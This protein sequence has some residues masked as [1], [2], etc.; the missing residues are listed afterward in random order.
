MRPQAIRSDAGSCPRAA[1]LPEPEKRLVRAVGIEPTLLSE[2]DFESSASTSSTTPATC[3]PIAQRAFG[4]TP[5]AP[6]AP[7]RRRFGGLLSSS[8][9]LGPRLSDIDRRCVDIVLQMPPIIFLDHLDAG[10]AVLGDLIDVGAF[11]QP[12]A[13]V[14]VSQAVAGANMVIAIEFEI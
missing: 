1:D 6:V 8:D 4:A 10:A 5:K 7:L 2:L 11:E 9:R 3:S 14:C 13:D 12:Q